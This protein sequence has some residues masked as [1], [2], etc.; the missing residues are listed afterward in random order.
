MAPGRPAV[1]AAVRNTPFRTAAAS[2]GGVVRRRGGPRNR[3]TVPEGAVVPT[4]GC[5]RKSRVAGAVVASD[6][7]GPQDRGARPLREDTPMFDVTRVQAAPSGD[8]L[9]PDDAVVL[10]VDHWP[11]M[12]LGTG[13]RPTRA[14]TARASCTR[15]PSSAR[16]RPAEPPLDIGLLILRQ[17]GEEGGA[18][19]PPGT[20]SSAPPPRAPSTASGPG[21]RTSARTCPASTSRP[22]SSTATPTAPRPSTPRRSRSP[23]A[24]PAPSRRSC[25]AARTA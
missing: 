24:S 21:S 6:R 14:R 16:T 19:G 17:V 13:S 18:S 2:C 3:P 23:R 15:R 12:F 8:L 25:P 5:G 20:S 7:A 11:Q 10:F 4:P 22:R 9:T 1:A